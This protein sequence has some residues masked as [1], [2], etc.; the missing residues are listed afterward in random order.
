MK[1][2]VIAFILAIAIVVV[3]AENETL[4]D[5]AESRWVNH[6]AAESRK[7]KIGRKARYTKAG[8]WY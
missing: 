4:E 3:G 8:Y 2:L 6:L 1:L 5:K 7:K